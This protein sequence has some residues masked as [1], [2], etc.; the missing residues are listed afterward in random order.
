MKKAQN[1]YKGHDHYAQRARREG[2]AARSYYKLEE[3]DQ[4][5]RLLRPGQR[6]LDLGCAPGSWLQY[7][8]QRIGPSG[9]AL[10]LDLQPVRVALP[11][12]ALAIVADVLAWPTETNPAIGAE[13][14][15]EIS[16]EISAEFTAGF[17]AV[18][19]DMAPS[20]SGIKSADAARSAELAERAL[21]IAMTS[22]RPG[23]WLLVKAFQGARFPELRRAFTEVFGTVSVEK[24]KASRAESVEVFLLGRER[25]A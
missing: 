20:T 4:R 10:G 9:R 19:S 25:R 5:H 17:D 11:P 8:A 21:A 16:T 1:R 7:A 24:P 3:I 14:S 22:L 18:L 15:T 23:G 12:N 13:I 6:V 2:V